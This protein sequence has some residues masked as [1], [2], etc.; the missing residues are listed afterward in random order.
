MEK[1]WAGFHGVAAHHVD[2]PA[3]ETVGSSYVGSDGSADR[4]R[5]DPDL[6]QHSRRGEVE[7]AEVQAANGRLAAALVRAALRVEHGQ[8]IREEGREAGREAGRE[9]DRVERL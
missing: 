7:T 2:V 6:P 4:L 8:V 1:S 3:R 5:F 9:D